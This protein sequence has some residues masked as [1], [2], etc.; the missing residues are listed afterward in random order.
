MCLLS[1]GN[2]HSHHTISICKAIHPPTHW[3][4]SC[5]PPAKRYITISY[6]FC[7]VM[8]HYTSETQQ[9]QKLSWYPSQDNSTPVTCKCTETFKGKLYICLGS[10][11]QLHLAEHLVI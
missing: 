11:T 9:P 4:A 5:A 2:V 3:T 7:A 8:T 6:S 10:G 1:D